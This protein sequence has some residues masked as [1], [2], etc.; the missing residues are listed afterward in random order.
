MDKVLVGI[1]VPSVKAISDAFVPLDLPIS[2]LTAML[3][4]GFQELTNGKYEVSSLEMISLEDPR[5]LLNP[6]FTLRDYG[7]RDGM[8]LYL[9]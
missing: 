5:Q 7:V 9:I 1:H 2:E 8:Q 4:D 6:L 3:A